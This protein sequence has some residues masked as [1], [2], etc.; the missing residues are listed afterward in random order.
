MFVKSKET[1]GRQELVVFKNSRDHAD[2]KG[3]FQVL[4]DF[5]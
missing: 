2:E 3:K 5:F 4:T 1:N